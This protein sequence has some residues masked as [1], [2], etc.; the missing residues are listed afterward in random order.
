M[1]AKKLCGSASR[2]LPSRA[3]T[4]QRTGKTNVMNTNT[5]TKNSDMRISFRRSN[6]TR[7]SKPWFVMVSQFDTDSFPVRVQFLQSAP[8]QGSKTSS[9]NNRLARR[10][11]PQRQPQGQTNP[12][13]D[14]SM[15][16]GIARRVSMFL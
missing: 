10:T 9:R 12:I 1:V 4:A 15:P 8:T 6:D 5:T 11:M 13:N 3:R 7:R 14:V 2:G 16:P